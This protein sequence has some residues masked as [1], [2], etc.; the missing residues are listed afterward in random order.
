MQNLR[1]AGMAVLLASRV[2][3]SG[4][5]GSGARTS[6]EITNTTVSGGQALI[7]LKRALDAGAITQREYERERARILEE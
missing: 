1:A 5:G 3:L 7:D 4:C 2:A 6:T